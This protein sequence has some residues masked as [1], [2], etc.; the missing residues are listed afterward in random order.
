MSDIVLVLGPV[1]LSSFEIPDGINFGGRQILAIHQ[2]TDGQ[3]IIDSIG[4]AESDIHF[5]GA[6]SGPR[7]AARSQ[8]LNTLRTAGAELNLTWDVFFYRVIISNFTAEYKNSVWIPYQITCTVVRDEATA[9]ANARLSLSDAVLA[10]LGAAM[11][12]C[13]GAGVDFTL[14]QNNLSVPTAT[15]LGAEAY[16]A[17]QLSVSAVLSSIANQIATT[18]NLLTTMQATLETS[19]EALASNLMAATGLVQQLATLVSG[20]GYLGR[21]ARNLANASS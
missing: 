17:A 12:Q 7:A 1:A 18:D 16:T 11:D 4:P 20:S 19:P 5:R 8:Q 14:V 9:V 15:T 21:A 2:L 13:S 10:D 3:R 6:F